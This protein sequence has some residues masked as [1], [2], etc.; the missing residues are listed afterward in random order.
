M[1]RRLI[2]VN[3][4]DAIYSEIKVIFPEAKQPSCALHP[5]QQDEMQILKMMDTKKCAEREAMM[6]K[7]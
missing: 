2:G 5:K 6:A 7:N 3:T 1:E 4:K